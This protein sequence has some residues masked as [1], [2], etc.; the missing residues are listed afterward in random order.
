[1]AN[2]KYLEPSKY[3]PDVSL[4]LTEREK[5]ALLKFAKLPREKQ[6]YL[7]R[8][9]PFVMI[10]FGRALC[11]AHNKQPPELKG[12]PVCYVDWVR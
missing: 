8:K 2:F 11:E 9:Y 5:A 4:A 12:F 7:A 10:W 6:E 3:N 1:M